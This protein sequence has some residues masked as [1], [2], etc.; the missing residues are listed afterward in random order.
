MDGLSAAQFQTNYTFGLMKMAMRDMETQAQDMI[1]MLSDVPAPA[2]YG[3]DVW[4]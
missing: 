2:Q 3:F 1:E 4:A